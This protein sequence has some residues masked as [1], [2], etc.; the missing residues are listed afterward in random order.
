[1]V[2]QNIQTIWTIQNRE[3]FELCPP[4]LYQVERLI[5]WR[6]RLDPRQGCPTRL[7]TSTSTS[8]GTGNDHGHGPDLAQRLI[9]WCWRLDT[10]P[11]L[12]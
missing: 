3:G 1:M 5:V 4:D 8:D 6:W 7:L 12:H 11:G 10:R 9:V 2:I